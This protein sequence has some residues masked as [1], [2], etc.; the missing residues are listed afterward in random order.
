MQVLTMGQVGKMLNVAPRT[1]MKWFD[2]GRLK[3]YRIPGSQDR[4]TTPEYL[5]KFCKE[6]GLPAPK[7]LAVEWT[8]TPDNIGVS[9]ATCSAVNA[10]FALDGMLPV[11]NGDW[12]TFAAEIAR[13]IERET[14]N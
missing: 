2:S 12:A 6:Y 7:E 10:I 5:R 3:G 1:A 13:V 4:R 8:A 14:S 11:K 9:Q